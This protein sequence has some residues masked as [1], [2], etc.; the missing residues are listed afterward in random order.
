MAAWKATVAKA[1]S[2]DKSSLIRV[3]ITSFESVVRRALVASAS[4]LNATV[5]SLKVNFAVSYTL[6]DFTTNEASVDVTTSALKQNYE[7]SVTNQTFVKD[8]ALEIVKRTN[9]TQQ[10]QALIEMIQPAEVV[11][12]ESFKVVQTGNRPSFRP[13]A[14]PTTCKEI[15]KLF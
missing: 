8:F 7:N 15:S 12:A 1:C 6:L 14:S 2:P 9:D 11:L 5:A 4:L 13:S 10:S 3:D